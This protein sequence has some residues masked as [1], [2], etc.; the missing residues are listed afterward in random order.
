M[1]LIKKCIIFS[2]LIFLNINLAYSQSIE[3]RESLKNT[4]TFYKEGKLKEAVNYAKA[5]SYTHLTLPTN[6]IV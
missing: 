4:K 5:V 1:Y 6:R 2:L 3:L